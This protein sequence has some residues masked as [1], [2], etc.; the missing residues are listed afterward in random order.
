MGVIN[1]NN[2]TKDY[3]N[4]KGIFNVNI[5]VKEGEV[6]GFLGPN[7]AGKTTTIRNL[8]GFIRPDSGSCSILELDCFQDAAKIQ[9]HLGYLAGEIAFLDDLKGRQLIDF[10]AA[11]KGVKDT[12]RIEELIELFEL[13]PRGKVKKMS[14]GMKQKIAIITAFMTNPEVLILDEPTSGLD[15]LM[16]NRFIDLILEEKKKGRTIF[17]SSHIFEE[18]ER[19]CDRTA[20]I[21]DGKI[22]AIENMESLAK[23]RSKIFSVTLNSLKE[24]EAIKL[25]NFDI[26]DIDGLQISIKVKNNVNEF[27][28][29]LTKYEIKDLD[30]KKQSLEE[31]FMHFY[32]KDGE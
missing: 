31:I 16:Q 32:G 21:R 23:K 3:G 13:D 8:L 4:G 9:E 20:I 28:H 27:L 1:I 29:K 14:K 17:M 18:I 25:E 6:F 24:I 12:T 19:T 2:L 30:I 26:V 15:P 5:E 7:G 10:I 22:V 11:M